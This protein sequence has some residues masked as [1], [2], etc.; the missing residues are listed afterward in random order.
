MFS[1]LFKGF[2][3]VC[4]HVIG[5]IA[6]SLTD[7]EFIWLLWDW[8]FATED[9]GTLVNA[10][11]IDSLIHDWVEDWLGILRH[12][13]MC[14][15]SSLAKEWSG[16]SDWL[17]WFGEISPDAF[18]RFRHRLLVPGRGLGCGVGWTICPF[19]TCLYCHTSNL[20]NMILHASLC[21]LESVYSN[22]RSF[23]SICN[24]FAA[25]N[26]LAKIFIHLL[27]LGFPLNE[28]VE[29]LDIESFGG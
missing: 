18:I 20:I 27:L 26:S 7:G 6:G 3:L 19:R 15:I 2:D 22:L 5:G 4:E 10:Y 11:D 17:W 28:L 25:I 9:P 16:R 12:D 24:V 23:S 13:D 21:G 8:W 1:N 29:M 14:I